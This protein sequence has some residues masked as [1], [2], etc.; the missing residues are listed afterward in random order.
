VP[1]GYPVEAVRHYLKGNDSVAAVTLAESHIWQ[2]FLD[3][4]LLMILSWG[5]HLTEETI[6]ASPRT[7]VALAWTRLLCRQVEAGAALLDQ[8]ERSPFM[9]D[10]WIKLTVNCMRGLEMIQRDDSAGLLRS[11]T[12]AGDLSRIADPSLCA[13]LCNHASFGNLQIDNYQ[14]ALD[15]CRLGV[16]L[17]DERDLIVVGYN[18]ICIGWINDVQ[19]NLHEA[20]RRYEWVVKTIEAQRGRRSGVASLAACLLGVILY[21]Q[22]RLDEL[23]ALVANRLDVIGIV[24]IPDSL[25]RSAIMR[26]RLLA[27]LDGPAA[28][29]PPLDDLDRMA[30]KEGLPRLSGWAMAEKIRLLILD[31]KLAAAQ[32]VKA[33]LDRLAARHRPETICTLSELPLAHD[34]SQARLLLAT[35]KY[36]E[37]IA[38]LDQVLA[39]WQGRG[40]KIVACQLRIL[41]A[42][43][44]AKTGERGKALDVLR[45]AAELAMAQGM[46]RSFLDEGPSVLEL[47]ADLPTG[48]PL[49]AF[50][51]RLRAASGVAVRPA[52]APAAREAGPQLS[53]R[54]ADILRL[55]GQA[56]TNK[57]IAIA[58]E[59]SGETVKWHLKNIFG[60][61]EVFTRAD[62]I[63]KAR[64]LGLIS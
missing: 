43:A 15:F 60:K 55:M 36:A 52:A 23:R 47:L 2:L 18:E 53:A 30:I 61:L 35:G 45:P 10:P 63:A 37:A 54:E 11:L 58:L 41:L 29:L 20:E 16:S 4:N 24:G 26:A 32:Q 3:E 9:A 25:L 19:G 59:I 57:R 64:R 14:G 17:R 49:I 42:V 5:G 34:L 33:E 27:A 38:L 31:W 13:A 6:A 1:H 51:E 8:I 62:A 21:E 56:M 7:M 48:S 39:V 50:A 44:H 28:G 22:N 40:R 46:V 12:E